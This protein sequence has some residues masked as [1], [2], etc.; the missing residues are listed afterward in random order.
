MMNSTTDTGLLDRWRSHRDADAFAEL[1][2]RYGPLVYSACLRVLRDTTAAEDAAQDCFVEVLR[3]NA[4]VRSLPAWLHVIATRRALDRLKAERRRVARESAYTA[5]HP[6][7]VEP[8]WDDVSTHVD[9]AIESLPEKLRN[10]LV[11]RFL[12][13]R[14]YSEISKDLDLPVSTVQYRL[15]QGIDRVRG[16]LTRRGIAVTAT[17]LG[18][19]LREAPA[20]ALPA[21][22]TA[23]LGKMAL[24]GTGAGAASS[25][26]VLSTPTVIVATFAMKKLVLGVVGIVLVLGSVVALTQIPKHNTRRTTAEAA[27]PAPVEPTVEDRAH[28]QDTPSNEPIEAAPPAPEPPGASQTVYVD[29]KVVDQDGLGVPG[30]SVDGRWTGNT[31][32]VTSDE[33]GH[34][35]FAFPTDLTTDGPLVFRRIVLYQGS[36]TTVVFRGSTTGNTLTGTIDP[37]GNDGQ[38]TGTRIGDGRGAIGTWKT[39]IQLAAQE[40]PGT[41][42]IAC[43]K[44]G[45]VSATWVDR[46]EPSNV[47]V[48]TVPPSITLGAMLGNLKAFPNEFDVPKAGRDD[49]VL[50]MEPTASV[51]G[52]VLDT[53]GAPLSGWEVTANGL[54]DDGTRRASGGAITRQVGVT[55]LGRFEQSVSSDSGEFTVSGLAM[56]DYEICAQVPGSTARAIRE[57]G[58]ITLHTGE[59]LKDVILVWQRGLSVSGQVL[60]QDGQPIAGAD[61]TAW[62]LP[63]IGDTAQHMFVAQTD[64]QGRYTIAEF[65]EVAS[66]EISYQVSHRDYIQLCRYGVSLDRGP[67]DFVLVERPL[68]EGRVL[69]AVSREPVPRFRIH[70]WMGTPE[71]EAGAMSIATRMELETHPNGKFSFRANGYN[72][73][74]VVASAPGYSTGTATVSAVKPGDNIK[75]VEILL[76]P[77]NPI[78][79]TVV[80]ASGEPIPGARLYLGYPVGFPNAGAGLVG[81]EG[82]TQS[83]QNGDF[84]IPE[85]P[86]SLSIVSAYRS[87]YAPSWAEIRSREQPIR[88]VLSKGAI[89]EG[90]VTYG[91]RPLEDERAHVS[92]QVGDE[93]HYTN[94]TQTGDGGAYRIDEVATGVV[95]VSAAFLEGG[96]RR[97]IRRDVELQIGDVASVDFDFSDT[98]DSYVEGVLLLDDVPIPLSLLRAIVQLDNGDTAYYQTE[99]RADGSYT[100]GPIPA[101]TFEFGALWILLEDG[102]YLTPEYDVITTHPGETNRHDMLLRTP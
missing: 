97:Y 27:L 55:G 68:I 29:G 41:L 51:S 39:T 46:F 32:S 88:I 92:V 22:A 37:S 67:Q 91:G 6:A 45:N 24:A 18:I 49:I 82:V 76:E 96:L 81:A 23:Q 40:I 44:S 94:Q 71:D 35:R 31:G 72:L 56:G 43:D 90:T 14:S 4:R 75:D 102:S 10:P 1:V 28:P 73:I 65:P 13:G 12:Q 19:M 2:T 78:Q 101:T 77:A 42:T 52:R 61:V 99:T 58:R 5:Q 33:N 11:Q 50:A 93:N 83:D 36:L 57:E 85:Y 86:A 30:A 53:D 54:I 79:G 98:Y 3:S 63:E 15:N 69:D 26:G 48:Q 80:D 21:T 95:T 25:A 7:A 8:T 17:A 70:H 64:D 84:S 66:L 74:R 89:I 47:E 9:E 34:F 62:Y 20:H 38:V 60:R 59:A 100:L 16:N 87:G